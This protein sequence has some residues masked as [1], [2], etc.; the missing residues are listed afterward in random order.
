MQAKFYTNFDNPLWDDM[1]HKICENIINYHAGDS[2]PKYRLHF[3]KMLY[4]VGWFVGY[5]EIWKGKIPYECRIRR[6]P[7]TVK[8]FDW[9]D[10]KRN[11]PDYRT[12]I[13]VHGIYGTGV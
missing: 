12:H 11:Y 9:G 4:S 6:I 13:G 2:K 1:K 7:F 5:V 8:V 3:D 10:V